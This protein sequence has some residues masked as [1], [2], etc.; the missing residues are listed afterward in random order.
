MQLRLVASWNH[1]LLTL[2]WRQ[3]T[4]VILVALR[5]PKEGVELVN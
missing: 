1:E 2:I 3:D 5:R 4:F